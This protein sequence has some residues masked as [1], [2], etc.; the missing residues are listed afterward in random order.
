MAHQ[1]NPVVKTAPHF[2]LSHVPSLSFAAHPNVVQTFACKVVELTP[3]FFV[4]PGDL[5][6]EAGAGAAS[7]G[8]LPRADGR[9][10]QTHQHHREDRK[11]QHGHQQCKAC[12]GSGCLGGCAATDAAADTFHA[13]GGGASPLVT[14]V[15]SRSRVLIAATSGAAAAAAA[16]RPLTPPLSATNTILGGRGGA[17]AALEH[18]SGGGSLKG[19]PASLLQQVDS[20]SSA[21]G[22]VPVL[23][24]RGTAAI[25]LD[26]EDDDPQQLDAAA[27]GDQIATP[28]SLPLVVPMLCNPANGPVALG[29]GMHTRVPQGHP[30]ALK[31]HQHRPQPQASEGGANAGASPGAAAGAAGASDERLAVDTDGNESF[32][33]GDGFGAPHISPL[34][35]EPYALSK[36]RTLLGQIRAKPRDFLTQIIMEVRV[37]FQGQ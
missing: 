18:A 6:L 11:D 2:R 1:G 27:V 13:G 37:F 20:A 36:Y 24:P 14:A 4:G 9:H 33:S 17:G 3:D 32:Q 15:P 16:P 8:G 28:L 31:A 29:S 35:G 12:H 19:S 23:V 5:H 10:S 22:Q 25:A 7:R 30:E 21:Q 34:D 26:M